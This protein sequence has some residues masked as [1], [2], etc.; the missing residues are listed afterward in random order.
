MR[1][2]LT[3]DAD[4]DLLQIHAYIAERNPA[5]AVSLA[6]EFRQKFVSLSRFPF[7]GRERSSLS[8]GIRSVVAGNYVIFYR[9]ESEQVTIMRILDGSRD[10][11]TEFQQ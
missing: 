9:V 2:L 3:E 6:N 11:D 8:K 1:V 5:V 7:I 10:I 4:A